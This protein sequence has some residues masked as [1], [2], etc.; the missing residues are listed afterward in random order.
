[1]LVDELTD[2][3]E[4]ERRDFHDP[5]RHPF[6]SEHGPA[7]G[8]DGDDNPP[9]AQPRTAFDVVKLER[10]DIS[11][12]VRMKPSSNPA[13][14]MADAGH[15]F[16]VDDQRSRPWKAAKRTHCAHCGGRMPLPPVT[17]KKYECEFDSAPFGSTWTCECSGCALRQM[18][19][20]GSERNKGQPRKC[21]SKECT[22]LRDNERSRWKRAAARAEQRGG[23]APP[24]P[25][26]RG[27]GAPVERARVEATTHERFRVRHDLREAKSAV[28]PWTVPYWAADPWLKFVRAGAV[29]IGR[30]QTINYADPVGC[31]ASENVYEDQLLKPLSDRVATMAAAA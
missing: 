1:M 27:S 18:V 6:E 7:M 25:K 3:S 2:E 26:D 30:G 11:D 13:G 28:V 15:G 29:P 10:G 16:I 17:A 14:Q 8:S 23:Q 21:C 31:A 9:Y 24:E 4:D 12:P 22:R 5:D 20:S 19:L